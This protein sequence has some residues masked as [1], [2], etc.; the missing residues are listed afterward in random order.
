[1]ILADNITVQVPGY[2][3]PIT[4]LRG[5]TIL[6][7]D[8][9]RVSILAPAG[10]GRTTLAR[11]FGGVKQPTGGRVFIAGSVGWPISQSTLINP[12][13]TVN[14]NIAMIAQLISVPPGEIAAVIAWFCENDQLL[15]RRVMDLAPSE[16]ALALYALSLSVPFNHFIADDKIL[17]SD[18][19]I[20]ARADQLLR[21]RLDGAGLIF[22]SRNARMLERW[23]NE[24]YVLINQSLRQVSNPAEG[25]ALLNA[26]EKPEPKEDAD[27]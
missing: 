10:S 15:D 27:V 24:H 8:R 23:C 22:L 4:I 13:L 18:A 11:V 9:A 7:R 20:A 16:K 6:F 26:A 1:M 12:I 5:Q 17:I 3:E 25:Q 14:E 19:H 21:S 2:R